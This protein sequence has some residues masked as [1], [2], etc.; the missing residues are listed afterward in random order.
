[1]TILSAGDSRESRSS[2]EALLESDISPV[3]ILALDCSGRITFANAFAETIL[4]L[5][6]DRITERSYNTPDW[7]ISDLAGHPIPDEEMPFRRALATGKPVRD[8]RLAVRSPGGHRIVLS[9][10]TAPLH[11]DAGKLIGAVS[12]LEDITA[13][14]QAEEALRREKAFSNAVIQSAPGAFF[15][16]DRDG[17]LIQWNSYVSRL[18][19]LS[20]EQLR[21]AS[22]L[23]FFLR[24]DREHIAAQIAETLAQGQARAEARV[25]S[26]D[27]GVRLFS[28]MAQRFQMDGQVY[29]C[30]FGLDITE[31]RQIEDALRQERDFSETMIQNVPG[32]FCVLNREWRV[33]RWNTYLNRLFGLTDEELRGTEALHLVVED[34]RERVAASIREVFEKG[35][36]E[37][38]LHVRSHDRGIRYFHM[39]CRRF[40]SGSEPYMG[41]FG[42]DITEAKQAEEAL[43]Q[44][45]IFTETIVQNVAGIF[46]VLDRQRHLVRWNSNVNRLFGL[47]D[48]Q[49]KGFDALDLVVEEDRERVN[50]SIQEVFAKG[51]SE[52]QL[53]VLSRDAGIRHF[54]M[55]CRRLEVGGKFFMSGFGL[56]VTESKRAEEALQ[57]SEER[58]RSLVTALSEGVVLVDF[59]GTVRASNASAERM[60]GIHPGE[61]AEEF[62]HASDGEVV[63]EDG[64]PFPQELRAPRLTLRTGQPV[65]NEL[66]GIRKADGSTTWLSVNAEPLFHAREQRPYATVVSFSDVTDRKLLEQELA[67]QAQTD[68]LT[69]AVNRRHFQELAER[70]LAQSRRYN[71]PLSLL[72]IDIDR[73]KAVNDSFGHVVG[74]LVLQAFVCKCRETLREVDVIARTG[75]EEFAVLLPATNDKQATQVAERLRQAVAD[76]QVSVEGNAPVRFTV[77]VGVASVQ[78]TDLETSLSHADRAL[79]RAK[80]LGRDRVCVF[81]E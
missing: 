79:Y 33:V 11:D 59:Q 61:T 10:D 34:E 58:Y 76:V 57:E 37:T 63:R 18:F 15:V 72:M 7:H 60:L 26:Q 25:V 78:D 1:V 73:F 24:Q 69:G 2:I 50:A 66:M 75:G 36:S 77:S 39:H 49:L 35:Y 56:D 28:F 64:S 29:L 6:R 67:R 9:V 42:L 80:E 22:P 12:F 8:Q 55:H 31:S 3:G 48:E 53:R 13:G 19:G 51:Y 30:G 46:C 71:H 4:G 52:T 21:G 23:S 70:E 5:P 38:F 32:M 27:A 65:H 41:G 74:D 20:D 54:A 44:E 16:L 45:K 17:R 47:T 81:R 40:Y 14:W 43:R 68:P 62:P